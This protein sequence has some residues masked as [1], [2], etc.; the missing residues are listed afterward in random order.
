MTWL[1]H[2]FSFT[3]FTTK[4]HLSDQFEFSSKR[5]PASGVCNFSSRKDHVSLEMN[6]IPLAPEPNICFAKNGLF[7]KE[8]SGISVESDNC[9]GGALVV[10]GQQFYASVA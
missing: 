5:I 7:L 4:A 3:V 10:N 6:N 9:A 2:E 1:S 8:G